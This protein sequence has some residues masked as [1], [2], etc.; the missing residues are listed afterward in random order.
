M[1]SKQSW[2]FFLD[3]GTRWER[4]GPKEKRPYLGD[5]IFI[6]GGGASVIQEKV[7]ASLLLIHVLI[8]GRKRREEFTQSLQRQKSRLCMCVC[9]YLDRVELV[10][11]WSEIVWISSECDLQ[12]CQEL[13][14]ASQ[15]SLWPITHKTNTMMGLKMEVNTLRVKYTQYSLVCV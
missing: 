4:L 2:R 6:S 15:Q 13:I 9:V 10:D 5:F 3:D 1:E 8:K 14:H 12:L 7:V 11:S